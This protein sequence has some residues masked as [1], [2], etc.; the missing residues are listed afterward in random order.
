MST[1]YVGEIKMFSGTFAPVGWEFCRGQLLPISEF[2]TLFVLVGTTYGGDGQ[3][4]FA[5]PDLRGRIP[6]GRSARRP[7]GDA[8][9]QESVTLA[10][11]HLPSHRHGVA[12]S[13][14]GATSN[15]PADRVWAASGSTPYA[16][17]GPSTRMSGAALTASGGGQPHENRPPFLAIN[18]IIATQGIFPSQS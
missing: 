17:D 8:G 5:V 11:P 9:G 6:I 16:S 2:E 15:A 12:A 18:F 14:A 10:T 13:S 3:N 1:P 7:L 4:T